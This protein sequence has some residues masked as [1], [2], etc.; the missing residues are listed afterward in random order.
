MGLE[1]A[2]RVVKSLSPVVYPKIGDT[3][4]LAQLELVRASSS[5]GENGGCNGRTS[6]TD[7]ND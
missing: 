3:R 6:S 5:V 2:G 4:H 7:E 1:K